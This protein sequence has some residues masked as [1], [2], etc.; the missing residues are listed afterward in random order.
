ML[1]TA[2][3]TELFSHAKSS[4]PTANTSELQE[5][6]GFFGGAVQYIYILYCVLTDIEA[7]T[8]NHL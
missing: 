7:K 3:K 4:K 5:S 6:I 2:K 8:T 1:I